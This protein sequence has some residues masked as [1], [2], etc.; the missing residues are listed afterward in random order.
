[1]AT[2][3]RHNPVTCQLCRL[4]LPH[5]FWLKHVKDAHSDEI[6]IFDYYLPFSDAR[7]VAKQ[8]LL[9]RICGETIAAPMWVSHI[10]E[11]H[12]KVHKKLKAHEKMMPGPDRYSPD[13]A[14]APWRRA[15][16]QG[17]FMP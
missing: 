9:C 11:V 8:V 14:L 3:R 12:K 15:M 2:T 13:D 6:R 5:R 1:M 4:E 10:K 16:G 17:H 7:N